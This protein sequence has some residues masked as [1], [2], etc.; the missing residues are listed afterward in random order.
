MT[1]RIDVENLHV[2]DG[3]FLAVEGATITVAS[4]VVTAFIGLFQKRLNL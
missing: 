2:Y 4:V 3:E 1:V